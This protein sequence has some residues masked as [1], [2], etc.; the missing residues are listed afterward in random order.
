MIRKL[1]GKFCRFVVDS[2]SQAPI[3]PEERDRA[4][5]ESAAQMRKHM[6][7]LRATIN[8]NLPAVKAA[9]AAMA[10]GGQQ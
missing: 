2:A 8:A 5:R 9:R 3:S 10:A 6:E 7:E 4:L 1:W